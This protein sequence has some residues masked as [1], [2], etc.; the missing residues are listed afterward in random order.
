MANLPPN[1]VALYRILTEKSVVGF[2]KYADMTIHDVLCV[3]EEYV[4]WLYAAKEKI[5]LCRAL[6][7]RFGLPDIPKPGVN[8]QV[9][10]DY[11]DRISAQFTAEERMHGAFKKKMGKRAEARA[12]LC[13]VKRQ[14]TFTK[15]EL[16][17]MN[18]GHGKIR[19]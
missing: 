10:Y 9:F 16:Q 5:S 13:D 3:D 17:S 4:V 6:K 7:E 2:G 1:S 19:H 12:I 14:V 18:H 15:G 11:K 8:M